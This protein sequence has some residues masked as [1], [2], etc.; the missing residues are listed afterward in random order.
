MSRRDEM[1]TQIWDFIV[2]IVGSTPTSVQG[3]NL[4]MVLAMEYD[5]YLKQRLEAE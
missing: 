3:F 5:K 1:I 4:G 2:Y